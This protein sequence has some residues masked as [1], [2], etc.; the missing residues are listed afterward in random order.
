MN[1]ITANN[2]R[3]GVIK[4]VGHEGRSAGFQTCCIADFQVGWR[5]GSAVHGPAQ[6]ETGVLDLPR[7]AGLETCDTADLEAWKSALLHRMA[8]TSNR[9]LCEG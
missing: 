1:A 8:D 7:P 6:H 4:S 5:Y 9:T 3:G 2:V